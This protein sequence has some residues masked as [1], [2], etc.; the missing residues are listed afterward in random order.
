MFR[1]SVFANAARSIGLGI[2]IIV[3][4]PSTAVAQAS[5]VNGSFRPFVT[6]LRPVVGPGVVGGVKVDAKGIVRLTAR[7][8]SKRLQAVR[9][10]LARDVSRDVKRRSSLRR[11]SLRRLNETLRRLKKAGKPIGDELRFLAGMQRIRYVFVYPDRKDIVLVGY[12]EGWK[13]DDRGEIVGATTGRPPLQLDD[14]VVALRTAKS[15]KVA[16]ISCSIDPTPG[17]VKRLRGLLSRRGLRV[18][19]A[20]LRAMERAMGPQKVTIEGVSPTTHFAHVLLAAD[21]RMKRLAMGLEPSPVDGLPDYLKM[22][23]S[24][25]GSAPRDSMPRWWL[26]PQYES[27]RKGERG[28]AWEIRGRSVRAETEKNAHAL[29]KKW[30]GLMTERYD[31]LSK[32]IPVFAKLQ[33]CMDLAVIAA[34][35]TDYQLPKVAGVE[36]DMLMDEKKSQVAKLPV[37]TKLASHAS[38]VRRGREWIIS[39]SGGVEMNPWKTLDKPEG[40]RDAKPYAKV[41]ATKTRRWWWDP[42]K[43]SR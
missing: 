25:S 19:P 16:T 12:A 4:I 8:D 9:A 37:P 2:T 34:I 21:V 26:A 22:I 40:W 41:T 11:I 36:L 42:A 6:G 20:T 32:S 10:Q 31:K 23:R 17:G 5:I 13:L 33:N 15:T 24:P 28:L 1:V 7:V 38:A 29:A 27:L 14:L 3:V 43:S 39:V 35:V 18:T 30:A